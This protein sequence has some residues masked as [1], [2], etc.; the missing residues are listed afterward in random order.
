MNRIPKYSLVLLSF[1][2]LLSSCNKRNRFEIDTTKNRYEVKIHRFDKDLILLDTFHIKAS[3]DSLYSN[4]P[5]FLPIFTENILETPSSD[6]AEVKKL[7]LQFLSDTTF[8]PVNKKTLDAFNN[9][10]DIEKT[11]SKAYTY[12]LYYFPEIA[13]PEIYFYVSGF[14]RSVMLNEKFIALGTD[15]YLGSDFEPYKNLTYKYLLYNMRR[16]CMA[17]DLVSATLF[18]MFVMN[19]SQDRLIDNMIFRGK[20]M[21]LLSVFMPDENKDKLMGYTPEQWEWCEDY[22]KQIWTAIIDQKDLFS[23]DKLLIR[24]YMNDAPFTSPIS[25]ESPGRL[26]TWIGWRIVTSYMNKNTNIDLKEL[27]NENNSQ[28]ILE[29]SAYRP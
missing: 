9:V 8:M 20:V 25:Q 10:S 2:L 1:F 27:M 29:N 16:E 15:M 23:T 12:I 5:D 21:Y 18:R 7:V 4:Y 11:V 17:T 19:S 14:N 13:L 26:G 28:K 6:T 3:M 24:K 22:E